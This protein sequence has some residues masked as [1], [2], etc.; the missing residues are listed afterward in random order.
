MHIFALLCERLHQLDLA[1]ELLVQ[2]ISLLERAYEETEDS[3]TEYRYATAN[4]NLGRIRL[5]IGDYEGAKEVFSVVLGLLGGD[6]AEPETRLSPRDRTAALIRVQ[7]HFGKGMACFKSDEL[8]DA[9]SAFEAAADA[10][11]TGLDDVKGHV[12]ILTAQAL[13]AIGSEEAQETAREQLL[14]RWGISCLKAWRSFI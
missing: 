13:W 12:T 3:Q 6:A 14:E 4:V 7:A 11:P 8:E 1:A 9:L 5:A 10:V 2:A